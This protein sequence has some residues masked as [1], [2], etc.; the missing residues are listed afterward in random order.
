MSHSSDTHI[1]TFLTNHAHVLVCL[2]ED[3]DMRL[4]D[5]A[6]RVGI[7]ERAVQKIVA[8][9]EAAGIL[10]RERSGR[11]NHYEINSDAPLRHPVESHRRVGEL[12]SMVISE[13]HDLSAPPERT[14]NN[15]FGPPRRKSVP[16][17]Q[18]DQL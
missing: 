10:I 9:L 18:A 12:L 6:D 11:R 14:N 16:S 5:V 1:W 13:D 7:T 15:G 3:H 4:R 2:A 8:D 17:K